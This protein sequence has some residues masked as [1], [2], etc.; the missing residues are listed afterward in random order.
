M[1]VYIY[2][3]A[4]RHNLNWLRAAGSSSSVVR[5]LLVVS[6]RNMPIRSLS[7][8]PVPLCHHAAPIRSVADCCPMTGINSMA[9]KRYHHQRQ[10]TTAPLKKREGLCG[11][12]AHAQVDAGARLPTYHAGRCCS[13]SSASARLPLQTVPNDAANW[14]APEDWRR[15]ALP[16]MQRM[17]TGAFHSIEY[18]ASPSGVRVSVRSVAGRDIN[19]ASSPQQLLRCLF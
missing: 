5:T 18:V 3:A 7:R 14:Q 4:S 11:T 17:A 16:S 10:E 12:P 1:H 8:N 2:S 15:S 6:V 19:G 13:H 9:L